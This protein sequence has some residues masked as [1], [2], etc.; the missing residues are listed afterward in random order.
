MKK[1]KNAIIATTLAAMFFAAYAGIVS[2]NQA[3]SY[4]D[5]LTIENI[6]ALSDSEDN[7]YSVANEVIVSVNGRQGKCYICTV[8]CTYKR[9]GKTYRHFNNTET[10]NEWKR[11]MIL[12]I[13]KDDPRVKDNCVHKFCPGS[14]SEA[15]IEEDWPL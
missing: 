11:C 3:E 15:P 9:D 2:Y 5:S 10:N 7:K 8:H 12:S 14:Q 13:P 1:K 4:D 6:E